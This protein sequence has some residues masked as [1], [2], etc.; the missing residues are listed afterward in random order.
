MPKECSIP[1]R[2]RANSIV[3]TSKRLPLQPVSS[4][5]NHQSHLMWQPF[6]GKRISPPGKGGLNRETTIIIIKN[7]V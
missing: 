7:I 3:F 5:R 1:Y 6:R 2:Y 4:K